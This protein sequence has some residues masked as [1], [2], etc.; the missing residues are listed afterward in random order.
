[1]CVYIYTYVYIYTHT[2]FSITAPKY[3]KKA[4]FAT[5]P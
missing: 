2:Y 3:R 4:E 1:M 5:K